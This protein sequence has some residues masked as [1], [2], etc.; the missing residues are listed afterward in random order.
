MYFIHCFFFFLPL[1]KSWVKFLFSLSLSVRFNQLC[2]RFPPL[3]VLTSCVSGSVIWPRIKRRKISHWTLTDSFPSAFVVL[4]SK[5]KKKKKRS[6]RAFLCSDLLQHLLFLSSCILMFW[7][8][9]TFVVFS[10]FFVVVCLFVFVGLS[11]C[12]IR[13]FLC[14]G[15]F[16]SFCLFFFF[17][18]S[19]FL[20]CYCCLF[21][22]LLACH[23]FGLCFLPFLFC[24]LG[25]CFPS[26]LATL[27]FFIK[28]NFP[29]FF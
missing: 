27:T 21:A 28:K 26:A 2:F 6:L 20:V 14:A 10:C 17:Y 16:F 5:K 18:L 7:P 3:S 4:Y 19:W 12:F 1:N 22:C 29:F 25:K 8:F 23:L 15:L 24:Q 13:A 11:F 9:T